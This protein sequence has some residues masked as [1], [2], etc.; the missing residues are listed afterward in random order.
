MFYH[1]HLASISSNILISR[2][3]FLS[4]ALS[5]S[6]SSDLNA[7]SYIKDYMDNFAPQVEGGGADSPLRFPSALHSPLSN[8]VFISRP[9]SSSVSPGLFSRLRLSSLIPFHSSASPGGRHIGL[10]WD[11]FFPPSLF[12]FWQKA[13]ED[14]SSLGKRHY[15]ER[16]VLNTMRGTHAKDQND[17]FMAIFFKGACF[18]TR[19]CETR[20]APCDVPKG[21]ETSPGTGVGSTIGDLLADASFQT[22][23]QKVNRD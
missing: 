19:S 7:H 16:L 15:V 10:K 6:L 23:F 13:T 4:L 2:S 1:P 9:S 12:V 18:E 11:F 8:H 17:P 21:P 20:P 3:F 5:H 14:S 22:Q